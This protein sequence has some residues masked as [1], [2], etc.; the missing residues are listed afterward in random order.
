MSNARSLSKVI[1]NASGQ[2]GS[3][4]LQ[5]GAVSSAKLADAA[6][7]R[8]KLGYSGGVL[9]T[10]RAYYNTQFSMAAGTVYNLNVNI[11]VTPTSNNSKFLLMGYGHADD[12]SSTSWGIGLGITCTIGGTERWYSHQGSHHNYV[13][14]AA[15]HYFHADIWELDDGVGHE[16]ANMPIVAGQDRLYRLYGFCH[17]NSCR[18]NA[19]NI[20]QNAATMSRSPGTGTTYGTRF[21]VMEISG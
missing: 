11:T 19:N 1:P 9:Q 5:D 21:I 18:W 10:V 13:S 15:D 6:I 8:S 7:S 17:N 12:D 4:Y 2:L 16:G 20:S 14:G 3:S